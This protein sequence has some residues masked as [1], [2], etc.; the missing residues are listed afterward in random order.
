V[1]SLVKNIAFIVTGF[2]QIKGFLPLSLFELPP[3]PKGYGGQVGGQAAHSA[4]QT[5]AFIA[6]GFRVVARNDESGCGSPF[7]QA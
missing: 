6:T 1:S 2:I 4:F 7:P 3:S 5:I